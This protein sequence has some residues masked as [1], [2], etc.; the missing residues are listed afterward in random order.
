MTESHPEQ[1]PGCRPP[2]RCSARDELGH[3]DQQEEPAEE[4]VLGPV[5]GDDGQVHQ[6]GSRDE[7]GGDEETDGAVPDRRER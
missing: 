5:V 6:P 7:T 1:P 3:A 4:P 2:P